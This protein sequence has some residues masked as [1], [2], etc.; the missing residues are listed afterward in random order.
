MHKTKKL[1]ELLE[2]SA[3]NFPKNSALISLEQ[4]IN[5]QQLNAEA[6][7]MKVMLQSAGI[8]E[9]ARVAICAPKSIEFVASIFGILKFGAA[10]LPVDI[11]SPIER[12]KFIIQNCEAAAIILSKEL[13]EHF[14]DEFSFVTNI[15][16]D[17]VLLKNNKTNLKKSPD[18]LAYVLYT[19]G[20]TGVPKGV[21]YSNAAALE[22]IN[23]SSE[24][25][26][27]TASDCFSSH[28][29]FHFDLSIF[30]LY[31]SIK[32]AATLVLIK[33]EVAKQPMLLAQ[34]M[35]EQKIAFGILHL[36]S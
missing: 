36:P 22:F 31:V 20:S 1:Y 32:H 7:K 19:S 23:W 4:K 35:S 12:N 26:I 33:E 34:L 15:G 10:Y 9:G 13:V 21:M 30:D 25:F 6:D 2:Y 24:T 18:D 5:Y 3:K 11:G 14:K 28:A 8:A 27:P 16:N 17:L 29:P